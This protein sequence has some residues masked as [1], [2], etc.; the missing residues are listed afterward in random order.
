M[1]SRSVQATFSKLRAC[2]QRVRDDRRSRAELA[3]CPPSE[4][5]RI[6]REV[7]LSPTI[8][9]SL[10]CSHPGANELLPLR[11]QQLGLDPAYVKVAQTAIYRD[12]ERVCALCG[13]WRRCVRDL[14][15]GDVQAGMSSY[16]L[17]AFT[18]DTLMGDGPSTRK[19]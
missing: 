3:A 19:H 10:R 2:L 6:A 1:T 9:Q 12:I 4:L 17:N 15:N 11:L 8:L 16:C 13:A 14:A 7:G 18:I 5:Q